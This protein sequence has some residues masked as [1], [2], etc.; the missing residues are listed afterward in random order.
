MATTQTIGRLLAFLRE[1][2]PTQWGDSTEATVSAW[3]MVFAGSDDAALLQA[4]VRSVR[5]D[6]FVD[7]A[8]VERQYRAV[9]RER[10]QAERDERLAIESA[11]N[12][13]EQGSE[14]QPVPRHVQDQLAAFRARGGIVADALG[15]IG[16]ES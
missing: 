3:A 4:A 14:R 11:K 16:N 2:R 5:E 15:A 13:A 7:T 6:E 10:I 1:T 12:K 8:T 9:I